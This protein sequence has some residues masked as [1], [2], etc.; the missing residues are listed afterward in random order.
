MKNTDENHKITESVYKNLAEN[1]NPGVRQIVACGKMYHKALQGLTVAARAYTEALLRVGQ[2]ARTTC[3]G[4][5]EEIGEAIYEIAEVQKEVQARI[6]ENSK[7]LFTELILPLEQKLENEFKRSSSQYKKYATGHKVVFAPYSKATESLK[8]FRKKSRNKPMFEEQKEAQHIK[9]LERCQEKL[10]EFRLSGLKLALLEERKCHCFLLDRLNTMATL[11]ANH[12]K[13]SA[14]SYMRGLI[15]WKQLSVKPHILPQEANRLLMMPDHDHMSEM[16]GGVYRNDIETRSLGSPYKRSQSVHDVY[17]RPIPV[18]TDTASDTYTRTL[19]HGRVVPPPPPI[20]G[21]QVRAVYSHDGDG[22]TKMSFM[23]GDIIN[24]LGEKSS[25]GWQYGLNTNAGKYGWFPLSFT[26]PFHM[27]PM[28]NGH[29][30]MN[31]RVKSMGDLL[32]DAGDADGYFMEHSM[33]GSAQRPK[34]LY[35]GSGTRLPGSHSPLP[36]RSQIHQPGWTGQHPGL[37]GSYSLPRQFTGQGAYM[38][39][40]MD[41][42]YHF[43]PSDHQQPG[44]KASTIHQQGINYSRPEARGNNPPS[45]PLPPPPPP[46]ASEHPSPGNGTPS[47]SLSSASPSLNSSHMSESPARRNPSSQNQKTNQ[48]SYTIPPAPLPPSSSA[49][50]TNSL[51]SAAQSDTYHNLYQNTQGSMPGYSHMSRQQHSIPPPPPPAPPGPPPIGGQQRRTA[52]NSG[53]DEEDSDFQR[54]PKFANVSLRRTMTNDR[55]KPRF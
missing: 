22:D 41:H 20:S 1:F 21:L 30:M 43:L 26:E 24:I 52:M 33:P 39:S 10:D 47:S 6:E 2:T 5:T 51:A 36:M 14:E 15:K 17:R 28:R 13:Q 32:D 18:Q 54:N 48:S 34:S 8:K 44:E 27:P 23:E 4:G 3:S 12:H 11:Y 55:S 35:E 42:I 7:A 50:I 37:M 45:P 19:P 9:T 49:P 46:L 40:D 29:S 38:S 31:G 53:T 16:N 25:D